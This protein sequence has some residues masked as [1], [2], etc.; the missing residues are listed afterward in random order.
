LNVELYNSA[1]FVRR[2]VEGLALINILRLESPA[3]ETSLFGSWRTSSKHE[4]W[5]VAFLA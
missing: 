5:L 2:A 3:I 1:R 4:F